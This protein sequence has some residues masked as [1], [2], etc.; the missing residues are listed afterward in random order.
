MPV[1]HGSSEVKLDK[2]GKIGGVVH[3]K[4][5]IVT[6]QQCVGKGIITQDQLDVVHQYMMNEIE[7]TGGRIDRIYVAPYL[8]SENSI[9]RKPNEGMALQSQKDFPSI[10]FNKSILVGDSVSDIEMAKKVNMKT[11]FIS[12]TDHEFA[13]VKLNSLSEF[14]NY[15]V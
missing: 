1:G 15:L 11:V 4:I 2:S 10:D 8:A 9:Y 14:T 13:D 12:S 3:E 5:V 7:N 6:N